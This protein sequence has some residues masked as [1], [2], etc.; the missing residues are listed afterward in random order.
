M[1]IRTSLEAKI[2]ELK[3]ETAALEAELAAGGTWLEKEWTALEAWA[4]NLKERV[5]APNPPVAPPTA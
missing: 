2:A 5:T 4:K 3:A 1:T